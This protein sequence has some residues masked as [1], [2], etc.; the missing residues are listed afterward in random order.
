MQLMA[1]VAGPVTYF[2]EV[3]ENLAVVHVLQEL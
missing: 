3:E 1:A 2:V